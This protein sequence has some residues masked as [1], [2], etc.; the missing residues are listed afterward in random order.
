MK[1]L[2][3]DDEFIN[4]AVEGN[5]GDI[6]ESTDSYFEDDRITYENEFHASNHVRPIIQVLDMHLDMY[7]SHPERYFSLDSF[8]WWAEAG[9]KVESVNGFSAVELDKFGPFC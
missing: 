9:N 4:A 7:D 3:H 2:V 5:L 6:L 8:V 1:L